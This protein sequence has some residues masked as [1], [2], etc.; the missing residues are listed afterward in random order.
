MKVNPCVSTDH[1][2]NNFPA[3]NVESEDSFIQ[4]KIEI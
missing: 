3:Y 1:G 2:Q 4:Q